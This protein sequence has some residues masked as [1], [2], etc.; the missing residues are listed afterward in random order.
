MQEPPLL[1]DDF[2]PDPKKWV[3]FFGGKHPPELPD[4]PR[5]LLACFGLRPLHSETGRDE[6]SVIQLLFAPPFSPE[7]C[8]TVSEEGATARVSLVTH[9][10]N[11]WQWLY[12]GN[13]GFAEAFGR[14]PGYKVPDPPRKCRET[15]WADADQFSEFQRNIPAQVP[16][17]VEA[18]FL[19]GMSLY[20]E[21]RKPCGELVSFSRVGEYDP[22]SFKLG[23]AVHKL[24]SEVFVKP[25]IRDVLGSENRFFEG[26]CRRK[27]KP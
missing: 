25:E 1:P 14:L 12:F 24:A 10:T 13:E 27:S 15:G 20:C 4:W 23:L 6:L 2:P 16:V 11:L 21:C 19:D 9:S 7:Y 3:D 5:H 22:A 18:R 17:E 26:F 8:V